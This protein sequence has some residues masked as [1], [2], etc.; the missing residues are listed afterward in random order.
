[1]RKVISM[2]FC[3][4]ADDDFC[5]DDTADSIGGHN[6]SR[7]R[8]SYSSRWIKSRNTYDPNVLEVTEVKPG[9]IIK[10]PDPSKS[11]DS[12]IY[13][14]RKMIVFLFAEDSG[15]GTYA[16]TQDGVF[17]TIV[18]TVKSAAA[19]PI[20]LLE[21]GAFADNDLVEIS[22]TFV[23]GGVNLF[24]TDNTAKCSVRRCGSR[25]WQ[26][27]GICWNYS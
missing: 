8:Q 23:A 24:R 1:M 6:D 9:S 20:T 18:A 15:R 11:F 21:V 3:G 26:S 27:Y 10:D 12:A 16:I 19:A 22:T 7:D 5:G 14:D 2:L 25:N 17:A 4:Y 13:P